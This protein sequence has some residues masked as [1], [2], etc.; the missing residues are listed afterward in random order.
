VDSI[1]SLFNGIWQTV[2][3]GRIIC[4]HLLGLELNLRSPYLKFEIFGRNRVE[5]VEI[6]AA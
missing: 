6:N 4:T 5:F 3:I 1:F 2:N